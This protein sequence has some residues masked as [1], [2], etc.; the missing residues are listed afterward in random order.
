MIAALA[1]LESKGREEVTQI[2]ADNLIII[3]DDGNNDGQDRA[4]A[5][6]NA[7]RKKEEAAAAQRLV[8]LQVNEALLRDQQANAAQKE[9][10][11]VLRAA[12]LSQREQEKST[13]IVVVT[14]IK[15]ETEVEVQVDNDKREKRKIEA[16][17]F[18]QEAIVANRGKPE[19]QTVLGKNSTYSWCTVAN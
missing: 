12:A 10:D 14:E 6:N 16:N 9:L 17:V 19:T 7:A 3:N 13:V 2:K 15:V 4:G 1:A 8:L 18:K 11:N 5:N